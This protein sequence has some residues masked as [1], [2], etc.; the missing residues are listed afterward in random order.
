[1]TVQS[2]ASR[3]AHEEVCPL[4]ISGGLYSSGPG[5]SLIHGVVAR[6][7]DLS[8]IAE[9]E[10]SVLCVVNGKAGDDLEWSEVTSIRR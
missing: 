4:G 5:G 7:V 8:V 6:L 2:S 3:E 1:M 9:L 10:A